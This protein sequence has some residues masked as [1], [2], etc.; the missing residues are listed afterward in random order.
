MPAIRD[1]TFAYETDTTDTGITIPMCNYQAGDLL[2]V[3]AMA[4][5]GVPTWSCSGFTELFRA[6]NTSAH[7]CFWRIATASESLTVVVS[8]ASAVPETYNGCV[9]SIRD[10]N[11]V[12][13][14]G[15]VSGWVVQTQAASSI[16]AMPT[17]T[18]SG[19]NNLLLYWG[20]S[21][22]TTVP[23]LITQDLIGLFGAD[24]SAESMGVGW[25]MQ[26]ASG[27]TSAA[28]RCTNVG[29]TG[30]GIKAVI[31]VLP[32]SGG[33][34]V[35]PTYCANDDS[36][37][38]EFFAGTTGFN[39][40]GAIGSSGSGIMAWGG[41][42][43]IVGFAVAS[44]AAAAAATD[45]GI[46]TYHTFARTT[47]VSGISRLT[48]WD[49]VFTSTNRP[50]ALGYNILTHIKP[51]T[52]A[53]YQR[54]S[55]VA[56]NKGVWFG[57]RGP[58]QVYKIFQVHG[59][60]TP[61]PTDGKVPIIINTAAN[62]FL[63]SAGT[64]TDPVTGFGFWVGP[65]GGNL[66]AAIEW[67][68]LWRMDTT[69]IVG[70]C[71]GEPVDIKGIVN[72][73]AIGKE[74]MSCLQQG[75]NQMLCLQALQ[76]GNA[77]T[78]PIWMDLSATAIEF[79]RQY[80]KD[81]AQ[82]NYHST[83]NTIGLSYAGSTGDVIKHR[84]SILSSSSRYHWRILSTASSACTY[85][86]SGL[87][88]IGAGDVILRPVTNFRSMTFNNCETIS[89]C[90]VTLTGC[91]FTSVSSAQN[92]LS[93]SSSTIISN[94]TFTLT[95]IPSGGSFFTTTNPSNLFNNTFTAGAG[96]AFT[97]ISSGTF[98]M[99]G[100]TFTSF[101][102]SGTSGAAIYNNSGGAVTININGGSTPTVRNG[103]GAST[104]VNNTVTLTLTTLVASS[105]IVILDAGTTTE[106][107]NVDGNPTTSY[108][109]NYSYSASS[110]IDICVYKT[111]YV[112]Y[113]VRN[114]QLSSTST[115]LPITQVS[116]RNYSNP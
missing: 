24:G 70:G 57:I 89:A 105:D 91:T 53:D 43:L 44:G 94:C 115:T 46:N 38:L 111:G 92:T 42:G 114:Y 34:N 66:T 45:V 58:S 21:S 110:F 32:P 23:S 55:T 78:N 113:T 96:H 16:Y 49:M 26:P 33:A 61:W 87:N 90:S 31:R 73:A 82:V 10:V 81:T 74:R 112:P 69:T 85:D 13:P 79:P 48:Q 108:A 30:A 11:T 18:A 20:A 109:Y 76:F 107:V 35:I 29:T 64:L 99:I 68:M 28:R 47:S 103:A 51:Q 37:L 88:I 39:G 14:F 25:T 2:L 75:A 60:G 41:S 104:T 52:P 5:T 97:I 6:Q 100:N 17:I 77:G 27:T 106:R 63:A 19:A 67:G 8:S 102:A 4:D 72:A 15:P 84:D 71:S 83:D 22:S 101:G 50:S 56:S 80:N 62:T 9:I 116:D 36:Q 40:N 3:F 12:T 93:T 65:V 86:F 95:N 59:V 54:L 98:T 7:V 1:Y